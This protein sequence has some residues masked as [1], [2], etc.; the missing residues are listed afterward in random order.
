MASLN[1]AVLTDDYED[2]AL[3]ADMSAITVQLFNGAAFYQLFLA[4]PDQPGAA[5]WFDADGS[6]LGPGYW[7][8]SAP[9]FR[10]LRCRG[11]RFKRVTVTDPE[12]T[13]SASGG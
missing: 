10:G 11:I 1:L 8:Y 3:I 9:D 6:Y 12:T 13:V 7:N 4:P 5:Q 2:S